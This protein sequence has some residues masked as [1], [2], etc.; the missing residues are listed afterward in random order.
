MA[1]CNVHN[2]ETLDE[3]LIEPG[4]LYMMDRGYINFQRLRAFT[5]S[6]LFL[7]LRAKLNI[8]PASLLASGGQD[9][10]RAFV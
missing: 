9:H 6:S 4:A 1:D 10:R 3:I 5:F 2:V 8:V 7:V